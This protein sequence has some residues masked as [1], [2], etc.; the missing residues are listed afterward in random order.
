M[1]DEKY[2]KRQD[3][4]KEVLRAL[5]IQNLQKTIEETPEEERKKYTVVVGNRSYT[6]E[7]MLDE[8]KEGTEHG[9]LYIATM[10]KSR[11]ERL[12]RK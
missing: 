2:T 12:R 8:V 7:E 10:A 11:I 1:A 6:L 3:E 4:D 5:E 9:E